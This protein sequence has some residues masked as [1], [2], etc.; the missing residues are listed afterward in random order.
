MGVKLEGFR[1]LVSK[2]AGEIKAVGSKQGFEIHAADEALT[3]EE[4]R[5]RVFKNLTTLARFAYGE[6]CQKITLDLS[7]MPKG[8]KTPAKAS[9]RANAAIPLSKAKKA[10]VGA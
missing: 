2:K 5:T 6:G 10:L 4:G 1:A 7:L 9:K 8:P 3:T